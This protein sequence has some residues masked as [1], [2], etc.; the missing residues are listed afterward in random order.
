MRVVAIVAVAAAFAAGAAFGATGWRV[1]AKGEGSGAY[2]SSANASVDVVNPKGIRLRAF[3]KALKLSG[4]FYCS[5]DDRRVASGQS[6][7]LGIAAASKCS[8]S[9]YASAED[10]GRL[11][12]QI[13]GRR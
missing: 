11:R 8:V 5:V 7:V 4:S 12:V 10:G 1:L 13:E 2:Y 9:A 6:V 3:G